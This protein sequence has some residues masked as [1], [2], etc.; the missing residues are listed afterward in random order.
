VDQALDDVGAD[1]PLAE[2][3]ADARPPM[4]AW[5]LIALGVVISA[6]WAAGMWAATHLQADETLCVAARFVHL[7]TL[8]VGFGSI[9]TIDWLAILW[10]L[11]RRA[12]TE[13][14]QA[15]R[16]VHVL[17]W[18]GL[19][20]LVLSGL[21]L[22]PDLSSVLVQVKLGLVFVVTLNGLFAYSVAQRLSRYADCPVPRRLLVQSGAAALISQAGWWGATILGFINSHT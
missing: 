13:L 10:L 7:A 18:L 19:G 9:I 5:A 8:I 2:R 20:G 6:V 17:V 4:P 1:R 15:V 21:V 12:L 14:L 22:R 3:R 16:A 11:G